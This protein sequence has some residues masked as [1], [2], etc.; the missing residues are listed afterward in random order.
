MYCTAPIFLNY[1]SEILIFCSPRAR[2]GE[3]L[4]MSAVARDTA[5]L[6]WAPDTGRKIVVRVS[7]A[8]P[9]LRPQYTF[10]EKLSTPKYTLILLLK[11]YC[12]L[13]TQYTF[14]VKLG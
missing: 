3:T 13:R 11:V 8:S 5:G 1:E 7:I 10:K 6:M 2:A 12:E 4:L 9:E 14:R